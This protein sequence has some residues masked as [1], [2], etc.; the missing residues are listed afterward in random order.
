VTRA[1]IVV[2][3]AACTLEFIEGARVETYP[4]AI[5]SNPDG[6]DKATEGDCRT[7]EGVFT[8]VSVEDSS[9]WTRDGKF[10]YGPAFLRLDCPPWK[11]IGIHGTDEPGSVGTKASLGCV[12]MRNEDLARIVDRVTVG[13]T[14]EIV[15]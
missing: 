12:R 4:V 10:A 6:A 5:G 2:R 9:G 11:G 13:T 15:P 7:P 14:V 3:K 1:R 8:I